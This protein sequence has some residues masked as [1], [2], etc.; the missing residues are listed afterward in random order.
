MIDT[1]GLE[2]AGAES[3]AG[4]MMAQTKIAIEQADAVFF[5]H[6]RQNRTGTG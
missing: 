6:R 4:R 1:A 5:M 2:E 3:L